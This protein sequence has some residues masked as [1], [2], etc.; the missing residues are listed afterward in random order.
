M[1]FEAAVDF[2]HRTYSRG[3]EVSASP[4]IC[5]LERMDGPSRGGPA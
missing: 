3:Q 2:A 1:R 5:L 4:T